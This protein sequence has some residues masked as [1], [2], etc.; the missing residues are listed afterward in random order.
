MKIEPFLNDAELFLE[1]C[2]RKRERWGLFVLQWLGVDE[3]DK[4]RRSHIVD[5]ISNYDEFRK[6][7]ITLF[8]RFEFEDQYRALL[9][10]LRQS[11]SESIAAFAARTSDY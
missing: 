6:D 5:H 8:G 1:V 3:A 11:A 10:N 9:R 2:G 4:V 7:L